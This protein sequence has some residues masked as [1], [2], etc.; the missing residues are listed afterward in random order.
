MPLLSTAMLAFGIISLQAGNSTIIVDAKNCKIGRIS[1]GDDTNTITMGH[2][3]IFGD[4]ITENNNLA[5]ST[6]SR[7]VTLSNKESFNEAGRPT[8]ILKLTG[9]LKQ[10]PLKGP[11]DTSDMSWFDRVVAL[12]KTKRLK[13]QVMHCDMAAFEAGLH[14][15]IKNRKLMPLLPKNTTVR[16]EGASVDKPLCVITQMLQ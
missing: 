3:N 9:Q 7:S 1:Q 8:K 6:D 4:I 13:D 14:F 16:F 10:M 11:V 2:N 5:L 12:D 15:G